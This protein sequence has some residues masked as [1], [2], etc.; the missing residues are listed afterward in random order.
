M[1]TL[2]LERLQDYRARTFRLL[3][4]LRINTPD[5]AVEYV[6]QCGFI[7]FW[8]IKGVIFPSLWAAV[9]GDR[10]VPHEHDDPGHITWRWKDDLL[11]K[12]RWYYAR[13]LRRRNT[14]ISVET[15]PY[16]YALSPNYGDPENDYQEQYQQGLLTAEARAIYEAL[17]NQGALDTLSLRRAANLWDAHNN[18]R[19]NRAL[20]QLQIEFKV[21]PTGVSPAGAWRYAFIYDLTVRHYPEL[22]Y[23]ARL[24]TEIQAHRRLALDFFCSVGASPLNPMARLFGWRGVVWGRALDALSAVGAWMGDVKVRGWM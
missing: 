6:N 5:Q 20:D 21:L 13:V 11:G 19:F 12:R 17:L 3:P 7:F 1:L 23:Q 9:A 4:G 10:P 18:S 16:F 24:I 15:L 2:D 8:P 14:I 22:Q